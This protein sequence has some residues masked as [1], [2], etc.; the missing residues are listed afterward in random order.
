MLP[1]SSGCAL[2]PSVASPT[3]GGGGSSLVPGEG[4]GVSSRQQRLQYQLQQLHIITPRNNNTSTG[5]S[6]EEQLVPDISNTLSHTAA[7]SYPLLSNTRELVANSRFSTISFTPISVSSSSGGSSA[8]GSLSS[9]SSGPST[10]SGR[11]AALYSSSSAHH[12]PSFISS[13]SLHCASNSAFQVRSS[14]YPSLLRTRAS[15]PPVQAMAGGNAA[16]A[17]AHTVPASQSGERPVA[18][19]TS[20]ATSRVSVTVSLTCLQKMGKI[21]NILISLL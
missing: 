20:A 3:I 5:S 14:Q 19:S 13:L 4:S 6:R 11:T 16:A 2:V 1:L 18:A 17:A 10:T 12:L 21:S 8:A 7:P 15:I 9:S